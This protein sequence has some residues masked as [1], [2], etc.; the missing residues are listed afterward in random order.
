MDGLDEALVGNPICRRD[1]I[2][3]MNDSAPK[4]VAVA[5][6]VVAVVSGFLPWITAGVS[7]GPIDIDTA[8]TG[9]D[10]T[11]GLLAVVLGVV[12]IGAALVLDWSDS[13]GAATAVAGSAVVLVAVVQLLDLGGFTGAG[14][15]LYLTVVAGLVI[16]GAG[17]F[18][19]QTK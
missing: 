8:V 17:L 15:G 4:L 10:T 12:A 19:H 2:M 16:A 7:A 1:E 18:G 11:P 14:I 6:G 3:F 9:I 13:A 5:G